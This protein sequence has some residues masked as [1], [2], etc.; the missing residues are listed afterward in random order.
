MCNG[1]FKGIQYEANDTLYWRECFQWETHLWPRSAGDL[2]NHCSFTTII[3]CVTMLSCQ[4]KLLCVSVFDPCWKIVNVKK[5]SSSLSLMNKC[6]NCIQPTLL[7]ISENVGRHW[8]KW[9]WRVEEQRV[10]RDVWL[11]KKQLPCTNCLRWIIVFAYLRVQ[12]S[13]LWTPSTLPLKFHFLYNT[14]SVYVT[15]I[16][17]AWFN[18]ILKLHLA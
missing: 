14:H 1:N 5:K 4:R 2:Y 18:P 17:F 8:M 16:V 6:N 7:S 12:Y 13:I 10:H 15:H 9:R 3:T 11:H